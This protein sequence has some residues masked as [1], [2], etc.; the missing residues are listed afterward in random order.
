MLNPQKV[1]TPPH[2]PA[3]FEFAFLISFVP[4]EIPT[5][6]EFPMTLH[7]VGIGIFCSCTSQYR[8]VEGNSGVLQRVE[9]VG[10][11]VVAW[12]ALPLYWNGF[13]QGQSMGPLSLFQGGLGNFTK[14]K[15]NFCT[16]KKLLKKSHKRSHGENRVSAF[17]HAGLILDIQKILPTKNYCCNIHYIEFLLRYQY[18]ILISRFLRRLR[19]SLI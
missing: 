7:G 2:S 13:L 5:H 6:L 19:H 4:F 15:L 14:L 8:A 16:A 3:K 12:W 10:L 17:Y 11:G 9:E 1:P 18:Y